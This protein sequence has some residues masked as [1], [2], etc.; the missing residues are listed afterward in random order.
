V[1]LPKGSSGAFSRLQQLQELLLKGKPAFSPDPL[2]GLPSSIT[3]LHLGGRYTETFI[4]STGQALARLSALRSL[5]VSQDVP[6][7]PDWP[8]GAVSDVIQVGFLPTMQQLG[9]LQLLHL[10]GNLGRD[11]VSTLLRVMP[12]LT[13][14]VQLYIESYDCDEDSI[15]QPVSD[16]T[17][18]SALL[19]AAASLETL[20]FTS[21]KACMLP[22]G[23]GAHM[24]VAG[25][26]L[27][28][29]KR[30][31]LWPICTTYRYG[32]IV[33]PDENMCFGREQHSD[34]AVPVACFAAGDIERLVRCCPALERLWMPGLVHPGVDVSALL[35]LTA[36]TGLFVGGDVYDYAVAANVLAQLR[37][38]KELCVCDAPE[39]T[40]Q[41]LLACA[42][43]TRLT[44]LCV[45]C[46]GLSEVMPTYLGGDKVTDDDGFVDDEE[47]CL[48]LWEQV[49]CSWYVRQLHCLSSRTQYYLHCHAW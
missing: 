33:W 5:V 21:R 32:N 38:L 12:H 44:H 7:Y 40:D 42:A 1:L 24:F 34:I 23:C 37:S 14:L 35:A 25:R 17:M 20:T 18:Y 26:K 29:L 13:N 22:V 15:P 10:Y 48:L 43:L 41:G 3:H 19:P 16:L 8:S 45:L 2:Q 31:K 36:L 39:F 49:G 28:H 30:L 6:S 47:G 46:C 27:L 11:T 4:T 9:R